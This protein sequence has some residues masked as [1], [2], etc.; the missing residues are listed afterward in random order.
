[1]RSLACRLHDDADGAALG[2]GVLDGDRNALALLVD[3]QDDELSRLLFARDARRFNDEP[4]DARR[5]ELC[6]D[7]FEHRRSTTGKMTVS[8]TD[9][10]VRNHRGRL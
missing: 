2:I 6:V 8:P 1:M 9:D 7:D 10:C 5:K 3:P 4:L